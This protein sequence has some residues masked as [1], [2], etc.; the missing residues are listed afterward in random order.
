MSIFPLNIQ[1]AGTAGIAVTVTVREIVTRVSVQAPEDQSGEPGEALTYAFN[2]QNIGDE[3]D[4]YSLKATSSSGWRVRLPG[5]NR[6]GPL[7]AGESVRADVRITI[8]RKAS[9]GVED[10]LTL[11]ATSRTDRTIQDSGSVITTVN[12]MAGVE[13]RALTGR[14]RGRPGETLTH[15]FRIRNDGSGEDTFNLGAVS[16][17]GWE[18]N[19]P[20]GNTVGPLGINEA[21]QINVEITIPADAARRTRDKLTLSATSQFD[22]EMSDSASATTI[23]R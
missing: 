8:S 2:V 22:I 4:S 20:G 13:V 6:I 11:T 5:G 7:A 18:I 19:I 21:R 10:Q 14:L 16:Q 12:Q 1:A 3:E 17:H 9:A 23:A 15:S